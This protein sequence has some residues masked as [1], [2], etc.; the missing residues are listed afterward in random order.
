M[1]YPVYSGYQSRARL[2]AVLLMSVAF[3][4]PAAAEFNPNAGAE[5]VAAAPNLPS[6]SLLT[7]DKPRPAALAFPKYNGAGTTATLPPIV[8]PNV[9]PATGAALAAPQPLGTVPVVGVPAVASS[10]AAG[11]IA[12]PPGMEPMQL[13]P[14]PTGVALPVN[15]AGMPG[16]A[17]I[18]PG[19]L[20]PVD[21]APLSKDTK[22]ILS[23]VPSKIDTPKPQ[24]TEKI[25]VSRVTPEIK[26]LEVEGKVDA[27]EASGIKISVR[28]PGLDTN[29]ELN[30]AFTTLSSGDTEG[31]IAIYK[32]ILS[33]EP[34]N[35]DALFGLA[36]I[37]HREGQLVKARPYYDLL[38]KYYPTHREGLTNF[39]A[40]VSEESPQ[41]AL[42]ELGRL[43]ERNPDFSPIPAQEGIL[44]NKLGYVNE[45]RA[46]MQRAIEL[47]PDNLTYKYN[48]AV[49][50]DSH[51]NYAEAAS[52]YKLLI[53]ASLRG[54][55]IPVPADTLQKRLNYI[56]TQLATPH[57]IAG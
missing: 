4:L 38:L 9:D 19:A 51:N 10:D 18:V 14:P 12:P 33:T 55:T 39:L 27:Y 42:A 13:P 32:N 57:F 30:R 24:K 46:K 41:E 23:H 22:T 49:M 7:G 31:A 1:N 53:E 8:F 20:P 48:L 34:K 2:S 43:E 44:L 50:L 21:A 16:T 25:A 54:E 15:V 47:A 45:S 29:Y 35:S 11:F 37:Y 3:A 6:T 26:S 5:P 52:I 36:S 56:T 17:V 40:L 28:R